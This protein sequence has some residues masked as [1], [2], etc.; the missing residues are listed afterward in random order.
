MITQ[1]FVS[2]QNSEPRRA[3]T[4]MYYPQLGIH[5]EIDEP[6]HEKQV[7]ADQL[8]EADIINATGHKFIR[9]PVVADMTAFNKLIDEAVDQISAAAESTEFDEWNPQAEMNPATYI[10][11]GYV[12]VDEDVAVRTMADA[13]SCFGKTYAGLQQA[14][15][16]HPTEAAKFLWFPKLY[17]NAEWLNTLSSDEAII[18]EICKIPGRREAQVDEAIGDF[19]RT[20][21]RLVFARVRS[22]LGDLM[23]RFK[24]EYVFDVDA[25]NYERGSVFNRVDKRA[26]TYEQ[27]GTADEQPRFL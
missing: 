19:E 2:R 27:R 23:Y 1:Q 22:P 15:I 4:D 20:G 17:E 24:G 5:V 7:A 8:R 25:S 14:F 21:R 3:M 26:K 12:D 10:A 6:H 11:K 9:I 18:T 16:P 13:A